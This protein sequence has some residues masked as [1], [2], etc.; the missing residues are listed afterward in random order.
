MIDI[1]CERLSPTFWAEPVNALT[2][3]GFLV[4]AWFGWL[5][6]RNHPSAAP[7]SAWLVLLVGV[8]GVGSFLF[9]TL[10]TPWAAAAD[11]LPILAF[12]VG[13]LW[14][15]GRSVIE[16]RPTAGL[17]AVALFIAAVVTSGQFR[18]LLNGSIAYAPAAAT[19]AALAVFHARNAHDGRYTLLVATGLFVISLTFR[20]L[21]EAVCAMIPIG[22]HFLWHLLNSLVLYLAVRALIIES[23]QRQTAA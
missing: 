11:V 9:H 18:E 12:Q 20:T 1:Y 7:G 8:I 17:A 16:W 23:A 5:L 4:A 2:N 13:F 10:A 14:I 3:V 6:Y 15:Y 21:D 22:T 19:L